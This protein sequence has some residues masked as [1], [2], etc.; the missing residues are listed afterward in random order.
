M[1]RRK[2]PMDV[3]PVFLRVS[4]TRPP[5]R[6]P[7]IGGGA[8]QS[9]SVGRRRSVPRPAQH[10]SAPPPSSQPATPRRA[11][12]Q[13]SPP[14]RWGGNQGSAVVAIIL[15]S[16]PPHID[17]EAAPCLN[18]NSRPAQTTSSWT[19]RWKRTSRWRRR[20]RGVSG[21]PASPAHAPFRASAR[22]QPAAPPPR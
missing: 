17:L 16:W 11:A 12:Q 21:T 22:W 10:H 6:A 13:P 3:P 20:A 7:W 4:M 19:R 1:F 5:L 9:I 2:R 15:S 8:S 18:A 14:T